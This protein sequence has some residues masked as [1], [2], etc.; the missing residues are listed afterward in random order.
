MS[1]LNYLKTCSKNYSSALCSFYKCPKKSSSLIK[2]SLLLTA[3]LVNSLSSKPRPWWF[4]L[5]FSFGSSIAHAP[6]F[7]KTSEISHPP[8]ASRSSGGNT[9][10]GKRNGAADVRRI[11]HGGID[12]TGLNLSRHFI[13]LK[14][15]KNI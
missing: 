6:P 15:L 14:F 1:C 13:L 7:L 5:Y 9:G 4:H 12:N 3:H 2:V 10:G 8:V 11:S